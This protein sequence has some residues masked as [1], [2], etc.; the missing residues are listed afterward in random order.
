[1]LQQS[2]TFAH[3]RYQAGYASYIE[4]LDAQRNLYAAELEVV[5]LHQAELDNRVQLYK[6]LG[7]GWH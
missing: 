6:A 2:L 4:E 7:G 3:D 1:M 5:R